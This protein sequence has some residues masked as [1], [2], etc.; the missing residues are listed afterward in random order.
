MTMTE[1]ISFNCHVPA[2]KLKTFKAFL[3]SEEIL[4]K[5]DDDN[6]IV[7]VANPKWTCYEQGFLA[8]PAPGNYD[9][10]ALNEY[11][12]PKGAPSVFNENITVFYFCKKDID[13]KTPAILSD[14]Q[15]NDN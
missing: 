14:Y 5:D 6:V 12:L 10:E 11:G 8:E 4:I 1:L 2:D 13:V 9:A 7:N 3:L 15:V